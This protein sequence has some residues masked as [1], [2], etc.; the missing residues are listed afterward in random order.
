MQQS[1]RAPRWRKILSTDKKPNQ[2]SLMKKAELRKQKT[3]MK[4]TPSKKL[5]TRGD[6]HVHLLSLFFLNNVMS[7]PKQFHHLSFLWTSWRLLSFAVN[8]WNYHAPLFM[9]LVIFQ[10]FI[11]YCVCDVSLLFKTSCLGMPLSL[12]RPTV[13]DFMP[14]CEK[15]WK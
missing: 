2:Q 14:S 13:Q 5:S 6:V 8:S 15:M 4:M 3:L 11:I 9:F 12:K 1:W 10:F 7:N